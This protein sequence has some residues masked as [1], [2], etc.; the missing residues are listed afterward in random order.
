MERWWPS[1]AERYHHKII[2]SITHCQ[3]VSAGISSSAPILGCSALILWL[4]GTNWGTIKRENVKLRK[5]PGSTVTNPWHIRAFR[6]Y[7]GS[8][9]RRDFRHGHNAS[10]I[11]GGVA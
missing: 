5:E 1:T 11:S 3:G 4:M 7:S 9:L 2:I 8:S 10:S 6:T